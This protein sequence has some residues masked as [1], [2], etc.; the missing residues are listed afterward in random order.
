MTLRK[1][2]TKSLEANIFEV[3]IEGFNKAEGTN[4]EAGTR[5]D[6]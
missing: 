6:R 3:I 2:H 5:L 4:L 1:L